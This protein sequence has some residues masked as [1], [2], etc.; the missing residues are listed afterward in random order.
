[1]ESI[2]L[3]PIKVTFEKVKD[4]NFEKFEKVNLLFLALVEND[5]GGEQKLRTVFSIK[6]WKRI[7]IVIRQ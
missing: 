6:I 5:D 3:T 7:L 4:L 2:S 1:V